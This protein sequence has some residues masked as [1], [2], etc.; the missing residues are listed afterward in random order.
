MVHPGRGAGI[1]HELSTNLSPRSQRSCRPLPFLPPPKPPEPS[2]PS[3]SALVE[4]RAADLD[5]REGGECRRIFAPRKTTARLES[6]P[7]L[8]FH[9]ESQVHHSSAAR[10]LLN[11]RCCPHPA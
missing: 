2:I 8:A 4:R 10:E 5:G 6:R 1:Q 11:S 9:A 7:H 3:P